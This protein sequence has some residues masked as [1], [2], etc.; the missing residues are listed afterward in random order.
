MSAAV[1]PQEA[2]QMKEPRV[3]HKDPRQA[4][5]HVRRLLDNAA[6]IA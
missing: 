5:D 3:Q 1:C 6:L 2:R 4:L